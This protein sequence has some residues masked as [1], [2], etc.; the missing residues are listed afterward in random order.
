MGNDLNKMKEN[1]DE[2]AITMTA[3]KHSITREEATILW[4]KTK[5]ASDGIIDSVGGV[6]NIGGW[7]I[8]MIKG[9]AIQELDEIKKKK[10]GKKTRKPKK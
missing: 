6:D 5:S 4:N 3:E 1:L 10:K 8:Q 2:V 9:V 7:E